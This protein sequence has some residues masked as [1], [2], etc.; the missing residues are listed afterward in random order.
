LSLAPHATRT[1]SPQALR[2]RD[3]RCPRRQSCEQ[4]SSALSA[5]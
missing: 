3:G 2:I 5:N 1:G 4:R